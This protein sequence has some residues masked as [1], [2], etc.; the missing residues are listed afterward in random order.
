MRRH[1]SRAG[2]GDSETPQL[3]TVHDVAMILRLSAR[4]VWR[5]CRSGRLPQPIRLGRAT[6]WKRGDLE[7]WILAQP[8]ALTAAPSPSVVDP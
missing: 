4:S 2:L 3:L 6:R 8:P 1:E 7:D 5:M